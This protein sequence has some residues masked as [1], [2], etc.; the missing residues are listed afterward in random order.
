MLKVSG[1]IRGLHLGGFILGNMVQGTHGIHVEVGWFALSQFYACDAQGPYIHLQCMKI[2]CV[3]IYL[4]LIL[5][6]IDYLREYLWYN[7]SLCKSFHSPFLP[8]H[9]CL[10]ILTSH[11]LQGWRIILLHSLTSLLDWLTIFLYIQSILGC[12][13]RLLQLFHTRRMDQIWYAPLYWISHPFFLKPK[14]YLTLFISITNKSSNEK[15]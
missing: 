1:P 15:K 12:C 13:I 5:L 7:C 2:N 9:T 8:L 3:F 4:N 14:T 10:I 6:Q 11:L